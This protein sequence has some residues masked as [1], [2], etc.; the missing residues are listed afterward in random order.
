M[1]W[2]LF[3]FLFLI[4]AVTVVGCYIYEYY[5]MD[6]WMAHWQERVSNDKILK[7]KWQIPCHFPSEDKPE[8]IIQPS[9]YQYSIKYT[10]IFLTAIFSGV[11]IWNLKTIS[12]I[13][14]LIC[15]ES[16]YTSPNHFWWKKLEH[17]R[18]SIFA[19]YQLHTYKQISTDQD[20][21]MHLYENTL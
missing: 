9:I 6:T 12:T 5:Y 14:R 17:Y 7:E 18:H 21:Y 10:A 3:S 16:H 2:G 19:N 15:G 4:P 20:L 11:W 1:A 8:P 13:K